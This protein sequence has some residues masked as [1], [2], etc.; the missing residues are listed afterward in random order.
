MTMSPA[1]TR[2]SLL[3]SATVVPCPIAASTGSTPAAPEIAATTMSAGRAAAAATA[4]GPAAASMPLPASAS[5]RV[6]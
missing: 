5:F 2:L 4:D 3:A 1:A 6:R